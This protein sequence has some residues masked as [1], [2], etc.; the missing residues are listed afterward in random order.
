[1]RV[2]LENDSYYRLIDGKVY[3]SRWYGGGTMIPLPAEAVAITLMKESYGK[4]LLEDGSEYLLLKVHGVRL[5]IELKV[6]FSMSDYF[7]S[8]DFLVGEYSKST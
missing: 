3:Y 8:H 1:K 2:S 4:V 5:P 6:R 7:K